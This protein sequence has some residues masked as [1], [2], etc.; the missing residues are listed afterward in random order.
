[1]SRS[2]DHEGQRQF[3]KTYNDANS[4]FDFVKSTKCNIIC[5]DFLT[6][7]HEEQKNVLRILAEVT[8]GQCILGLNNI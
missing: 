6:Q 1:M 8:T 2:Y 5:R 3:C 4:M 7:E